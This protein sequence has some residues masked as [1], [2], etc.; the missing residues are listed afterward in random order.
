MY[1]MEHNI[2]IIDPDPV[3]A[4]NMSNRLRHMLPKSQ[5][6]LFSPNEIIS[7]ASIILTQEVI[8]YDDLRMDLMVLQKHIVTSKLPLM[9]PLQTHGT[10]IR[11]NLT[12]S[13][14]STKVK[15]L[16]QQNGRH[17]TD[18]CNTSTS[19]PYLFAAKDESQNSHRSRGHVR[20]MVSFGDRIEREK[21]VSRNMKN[22]A[23]AGQRVVRLDLMP[24]MGIMNPF[25]DCGA[26]RKTG[27]GIHSYG[28]SELLLHLETSSMEPSTLLEYVQIGKDGF[29]HFGFPQRADDIICCQPQTLL[30]LLRLLRQLAENPDENTVVLVVIESFPFRVVR[31]MCSLAHELHIIMPPL[32]T[33]DTTMCD[34]EIHDLLSSLSPNMLTFV[35]SQNTVQL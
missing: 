34:C 2:A 8:M 27:R 21:Y 9:I 17:L 12:A 33:T 20:M 35:S 24:G 19:L 6:S 14:L 18:N 31:Q 15:G 5:I 28:I 23:S 13:E 26:K 32:E 4:L 25:P 3:F 1:T 29:F 30:V 11:R 10:D 22:T 16:S 7:D